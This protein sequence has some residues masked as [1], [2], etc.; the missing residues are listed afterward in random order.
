MP[1]RDQAPLETA[2]RGGRAA[3]KWLVL[4]Q[5]SPVIGDEEVRTLQVPV[6]YLLRVHVSHLREALGE[7]STVSVTRGPGSDATQ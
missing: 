1:E 3:K 5:G 7:V 6:Y 2:Q 4:Q